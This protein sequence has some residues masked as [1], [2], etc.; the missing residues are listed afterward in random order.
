MKLTFYGA[1]GE[2]TG[3][4]HLVEFGGK[5]ILLDCGLIQGGDPLG[6]GRGGPG[7]R[8]GDET[9]GNPHR[10]G[11]GYLSMANAGPGTNGSQFF[12]THVETPWLDGRHTV[13][14]EVL[15]SDDQSV[16][17]SIAVGDTIESIEVNGAEP[18][19][20][21]QAARVAEWNGKLA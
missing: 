5:R 16:V 7:Y 21:S 12:I 13:F 15:G 11:A 9:Y 2:V 3:S 19:L 6:S 18:L 4:C 17:D 1:A 14:G 10:H 20:E 8:F